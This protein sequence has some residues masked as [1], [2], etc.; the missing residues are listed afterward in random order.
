MVRWLYVTVYLVKQDNS[1]MPRRASAGGSAP[2]ATQID[3]RRSTPTEPVI[4]VGFQSKMGLPSWGGSFRF[5]LVTV[6]MLE[7][8]SISSSSPFPI[9]SMSEI[10]FH[11]FTVYIYI[12]RETVK[13][14]SSHHRFR[15][16]QSNHGFTRTSSKSCVT[17][18]GICQ[19]KFEIL[20]NLYR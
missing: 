19:W 20:V 5:V 16:I 13:P 12:Y 14:K 11:G 8:M 7:R 17:L 18:T 10:G 4:T 6:A 3:V 9:R 2:A 15:L 1:P